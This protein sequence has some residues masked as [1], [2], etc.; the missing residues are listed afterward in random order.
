LRKAKPLKKAWP[1]GQAKDSGHTQL[2]GFIKAGYYQLGANP[3]F[4][5]ILGYCQRFYLG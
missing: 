1:V 3:L 5:A 2:P 4:L